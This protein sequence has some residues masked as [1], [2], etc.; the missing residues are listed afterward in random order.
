MSVLTP[1]QI[2]AAVETALRLGAEVIA[3]ERGWVFERQDCNLNYSGA[4]QV[5]WQLPND[6]FHRQ[7]FEPDDV[8]YSRVPVLEQMR[9]R[10]RAYDLG[11]P[12]PRYST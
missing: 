11:G 6:W 2:V 10:L 8:F 3:R 12:M 5:T 1:E 4:I 7:V 9:R